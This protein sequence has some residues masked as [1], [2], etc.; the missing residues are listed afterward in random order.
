[1]ARACDPEMTDAGVCRATGSVAT[2]AASF[3]RLFLPGAVDR[4]PTFGGRRFRASRATLDGFLDAALSRATRTGTGKDDLLVRILTARDPV[5]DSAMSP[6]AARSEALSLLL[7]AR[8]GV[9]TGL[10]WAWY[11]LARHPDAEGRLHAEVDDVLGDRLATIED[12]PRLR[13]T[14]SVFA[15]ALRL[16]PPAW[17]LRRRAV[18]DQRLGGY[19][20]TAGTTVLVSPYVV[21]RDVRFHPA[22]TRFDPDR[23]GEAEPTRHRYAFF[24]FGGGAM[25]CIGEHVAWMAGPLVLATI[26]QRWRLRLTTSRVRTSWV[27]TLKPRGG[28][29]MVVERRSGTARRHRGP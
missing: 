11:L 1:M 7:G 2:A 4:L 13:F 10:A 24:P 6:A 14:R 29:P 19:M 17:L 23:F 9:A 18:I 8:A 21:Q 20:V 28:L 26:A 16:F 15:E 22:P 3:W 12:V 27:I 5:S 25:A